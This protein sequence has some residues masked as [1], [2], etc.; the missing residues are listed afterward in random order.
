MKQFEFLISLFQVVDFKVIGRYCK[1]IF[2][3]PIAVADKD[4]FEIDGDYFI[5]TLIL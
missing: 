4:D 3:E 5:K 2:S 1:V